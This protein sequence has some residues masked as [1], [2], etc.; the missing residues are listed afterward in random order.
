MEYISNYTYRTHWVD[1]VDRFEYN[2]NEVTRI[3][4]EHICVIN[5]KHLNFIAVTK[6]AA[7]GQL[8]YGEMTTSPL[9]IDAV[10]QFHIISPVTSNSCKLTTEI[11]LEAKSLI[12]KL[13]IFFVIK[14]VI[15]K[16]TEKAL[17]KLV[18][19][20]TSGNSLVEK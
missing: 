20:T 15:K 18:K 16:N 8:V 17:G 12:K 6:D 14:R 5:E 9:P 11:Y 4:T 19:F 2:H 10:Y 7:A 1:G 13:L 3:G